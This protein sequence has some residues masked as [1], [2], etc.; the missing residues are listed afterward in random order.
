MMDR[1]PY[2]K[3]ATC[4]TSEMM[5]NLYLNGQPVALPAGRFVVFYNRFL[6]PG[7]PLEKP[8]GSVTVQDDY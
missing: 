6:P 5:G 4:P 8:A 3:K 2:P 1:W 7:S